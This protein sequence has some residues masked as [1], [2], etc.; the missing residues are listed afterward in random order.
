[1]SKAENE[2]LARRA[3]QGVAEGDAQIL[4]EVWDPK[5]VWHAAGSHGWAGHYEGLAVVL[6]HI[7]EIGESSDEFDAKL[8]EILTSDRRIV[9]FFHAHIRRG[10]R[11]ADVE[12]VMTAR[13]ENGRMTYIWLA[14][15]DPEA[16][17]ALWE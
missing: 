5:V 2:G 6:N 9:Y 11:A 12:Y 15:K 3:W 14:P 10:T 7:A 4:Q 1:M 13:H 17:A 16:L 8:D